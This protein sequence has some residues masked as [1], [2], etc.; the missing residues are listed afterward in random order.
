MEILLGKEQH[1]AEDIIKTALGVTFRNSGA[2]EEIEKSVDVLQRTVAGLIN[3][4]LDN[5]IMKVSDV[6]K[7]VEMY[8]FDIKEVP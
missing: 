7:V 6:E 4:L 3:F 1:N 8:E 5:G 2:V